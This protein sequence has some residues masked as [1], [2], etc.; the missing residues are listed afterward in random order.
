M[1]GPL[2][3]PDDPKL[4][5]YALGELSG[6]DRAAVEAALRE[7]PALRAVVDEIRAAAQQ[8][9]AALEHEPIVAANERHRSASR[10]AKAP[11][12]GHARMP[13]AA[14]PRITPAEKVGRG[15]PRA[16]DPAYSR[17]G[18]RGKVVRF[19]QFYFVIAGLA[20][21]CFA[22]LVALNRDE[23]DLKQENQR[24]A[25]EARARPS[26]TY[27]AVPLAAVSAPAESFAASVA[28]TEAVSIATPTTPATS[29]LAEP[30]T[31]SPA[32]S[33]GLAFAG[34]SPTEVLMPRTGPRLLSSTAAT[35]GASAEA[36]SVLPA[37]TLAATEPD[38]M[39]P[40][41]KGPV[42]LTTLA[43]A[44]SPPPTKTNFPP[45][46][47]DEIVLLDAFTVRADI[48]EGFT[49]LSRSSRL[50]PATR[51]LEERRNLPRAPAG[52]EF[53]R[54]AATAAPGADNEFLRV[55]EHPQSAFSAN[56]DTTSYANVRGMIEQGAVPAREAVRIEELLNYFAYS[57][58]APKAERGEVPPF[59]A[60]L[61][62]AEAPW[63]P[64]HR[65]VRVG[66]KSR[67]VSTAERAPANLVFLIDVSASMSDPNKLPLVKESMRLLVSKLRPDDLVAIVVYAGESGL[68]LPSTPV[69]KRREILAA[70]EALKPG[71]ATNGALGIH[72]AYDIAKAHFIRDGINRVI[73]CTDGDFNVGTT[74]SGELVGLIEEKAS[75]GVFLTVL[76][77]GM[78]RAKDA[79]LELLAHKGNGHYGYIDSR[80]E[81]EKLLAEQVNGTLVTVAKDV[82][83]QVTFNPAKVASYR[84]IGYENRQLRKEDFSNDKVDAGEIGAGHTVTALYEVVPFGVGDRVTTAA[85]APAPKYQAKGA[86]SSRLEMPLAPPEPPSDELVTVTVRYKKPDGIVSR[87]KDFE[88]VDA[89]TRFAH[90]SADFRFAAA[91]AHFGMILRDSP[92]KGAGTLGDVVAWAANAAVGAGGDP[93]GYRGEFI[94][95]VRKTQRMLR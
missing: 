30:A 57:Y 33:S 68:A 62:V 87:S 84:L 70:L 49:T 19:P 61:E 51:G 23:H 59:A 21:A 4:T 45:K 31:R 66:L 41:V 52:A 67:E 32:E 85:L 37:V 35:G 69:A 89:G 91:V 36:T 15:A 64:A 81:A 17:T 24:L 44:V 50:L 63:A 76:G 39:P 88:L 16:S 1:N 34:S 25:A 75:S 83:I 14:A 48:L 13:A 9:T 74:H 72:L 6:D 92:H 29:A 58:P 90:A 22:V 73:L 12:R 26:T 54:N 3:Q 80:R 78:G 95:L 55:A 18:Q 28:P 8:M 71:G 40:G 86:V 79:T 10:I 60:S 38:A 7:E 82:K 94:D 77:F 93:G 53:A 65:L 56:V 43:Q 5:A 42:T 46:P 11:G 2:L 47:E 27:V 20:A